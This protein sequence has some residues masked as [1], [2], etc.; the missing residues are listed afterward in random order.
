MKIMK[1]KKLT[2]KKIMK[3]K[4]NTNNNREVVK[5]NE[6]KQEINEEIKTIIQKT[7]KF[8]N[9]RIAKDTNYETVLTGVQLRPSTLF[10]LKLFEN[11]KI[12]FSK[13]VFLF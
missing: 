1:I 13:P 4:K 12:T 2:K 11:T 9:Y 3:S 6:I 8:D 10:L 5:Q 7:S